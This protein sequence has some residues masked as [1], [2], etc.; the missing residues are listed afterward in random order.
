MRAT[1]RHHA[2]DSTPDAVIVTID[3]SHFVHFAFNFFFNAAATVAPG[4]SQNNEN[5][6]WKCRVE[7]IKM[8]QPANTASNMS[9]PLSVSLFLF[10]CGYFYIIFHYFVKSSSIRFPFG[11]SMNRKR[12]ATV[13]FHCY[14]FF[15]LSKTFIALSREMNGMN[16]TPKRN[17]FNSMLNIEKWKVAVVMWLYKRFHVFSHWKHKHKQIDFFPIQ[18]NRIIMPCISRSANDLPMPD[19][20][21]SAILK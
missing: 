8:W 19:P 6:E 9:L 14:F 1:L 10:D 13:K 12:I 3:G 17:E 15:C 21:R 16:D 18:S 2:I 5:G 20:F 7:L 4:R 11:F